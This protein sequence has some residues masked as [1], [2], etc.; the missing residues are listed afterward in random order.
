MRETITIPER[1]NGPPG[2][3]NGG[4]ACGLV[5]ALVDGDAEVTLRSP[6]P[7]ATPITVERAGARV[8]VRDGETLVAE[9]EPVALELDVPSPVSLAAAEAARPRYA[10]F[11]HHAYATCFVCGPER[12]DGLGIF[13]GPVEGRELVAAPWAPPTGH[14]ADEI[15]WAALDCPSGW[16]VDE[17]SREGVLLGRLAARL[18]GAVVG[19]EPH[20]VVGWPIGEEG[21]KRY[22]GSAIF[23]AAGE[24][25]AYAR[26]TW[27]VPRSA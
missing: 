25:R 5:A 20:V 12:G 14:V 8:T 17:F 9:A 21:R 7:L 15:V 2:S 1:F 27:L 19:G 4:Y 10:G 22:A 6:P 11:R 13:A 16:A 23:T 26:S 3:A 24:L 18:V